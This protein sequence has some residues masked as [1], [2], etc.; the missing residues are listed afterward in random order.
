MGCGFNRCD[1]EMSIHTAKSASSAKLYLIAAVLM[2]IQTG[3]IFV[4][5]GIIPNTGGMDYWLVMENLGIAQWVFP[6][7]GVLFI[8]GR[9]FAKT[10]FGVTGTTERYVGGGY[11]RTTVEK[12][13][14]I[15]C[16]C[17]TGIAVIG[18]SIGLVFPLL[19]WTE[20]MAGIGVIPAILAGIVAMV[21]G[22]KS[23]SATVKQGTGKMGQAPSVVPADSR[24]CPYC[25]KTG[26]S[27]YATSCPSCGQPLS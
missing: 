22:Y 7:I 20:G 9:F 6:I 5:R 1:N 21:A 17:M 23:L 15:T 8:I 16:G 13:N 25:N 4:V 24:T 26:I 3:V 11:Y 14:G 27:P 18:V 2:F 10:G 19:D 12:A